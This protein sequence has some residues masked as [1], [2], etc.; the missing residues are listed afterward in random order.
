MLAAL[1]D[2]EPTYRGILQELREQYVLGYYP[3]DLQKDGS[4]R[5][6][7]V[8]VDSGSQVRAREGYLDY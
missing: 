4:W 8:R 7:R 5:P 1:D 6:V 3:T 2:L